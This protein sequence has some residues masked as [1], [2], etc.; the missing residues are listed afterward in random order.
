MNLYDVMVDSLRNARDYDF[1]I[2]SKIL[3]NDRISELVEHL[4]GENTDPPLLIRYSD[5]NGNS[6]ETPITESLSIPFATEITI[7]PFT[8]EHTRKAL[9]ILV[10]E[11]ERNT[12]IAID[13]LEFFDCH[14]PAYAPFG[15][16]LVYN[17][18]ENTTVENLLPF[19]R[20]VYESVKKQ[21]PSCEF[22]PSVN[23]PAMF[24]YKKYPEYFKHVGIEYYLDEAKFGIF[25]VNNIETYDELS[26][27]RVCG[28]IIVK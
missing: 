25:S 10:R 22:F 15:I 11:D 5:S 12:R 14:I 21:Y 7:V 9:E 8:K 17:Y 20:T 26:Y 23:E 6:V 27:N 13:N 16:E 4:R 2:L 1:S 18:P 28:M 19:D 3:H 24:C